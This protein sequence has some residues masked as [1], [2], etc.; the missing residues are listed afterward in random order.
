M[1]SKLGTNF[2]RLS[3]LEI[4][5][6]ASYELPK[7]R[8]NTRPSLSDGTNL[9]IGGYGESLRMAIS[10]QAGGEKVISKPHSE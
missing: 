8:S 6:M 5:H 9:L 7:G 3:I 2:F 1:I 10:S 4:D